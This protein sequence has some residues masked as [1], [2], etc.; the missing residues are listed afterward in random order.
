MVGQEGLVYIWGWLCMLVCKCSL[1]LLVDTLS[2]VGNKGLCGMGPFFSVI[3]LKVLIISFCPLVS[4]F[5]A[6]MRLSKAVLSSS[7]IISL[8]FPNWYSPNQFGTDI[9]LFPKSMSS[10]SSS[11]SL[12]LCLL[13]VML[14]GPSE[15]IY[16]F[17]C[18]QL[19]RKIALIPL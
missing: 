11:L 4:S 19:A 6:D 18:P 13:W 5:M 15:F 16:I 17:A 14:Y 8:P 7:A 1:L 9:P 12:Y 2:L 3:C 10:N